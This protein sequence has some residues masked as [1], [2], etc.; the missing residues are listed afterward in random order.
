[1]FK[2]FKERIFILLLMLLN[3]A[4]ANAQV[5]SFDFED[6]S[7]HSSW[8]LNP[9]ANQTLI[10]RAE[11][12]WYIGYSG[13]RSENG[14]Y[15]LFM[16]NDGTHATYSN[17]TG[18]I[19]YA[20]RPISFSA[21]SYVL[22]F[23]WRCNA[24]ASSGEGMYV[25][26]VPVAD[27][28]VKLNSG[29]QVL[30][31]WV[32]NYS[33][34]LT[35]MGG[36]ATWQVFTFD[37]TF[38]ADMLSAF[39]S[40]YYL[41]FIWFQRGSNINTPSSACIDNICIFDEKEKCQPPTKLAYSI[42]PTGLKLSWSGGA[43]HY[44]IKLYD[45]QTNSWEVH[46]GITGKTYT[47][48]NMSEGLNDIYIR[49]RCAEDTL[50]SEYVLFKPFY[51]QRGVRCI[52]YLSL[53]DPTQVTCYLGDFDNQRRNVTRVSMINMLD[54]DWIEY[55][56]NLFALHYMPDEYDPYTNNKLPTKPE[57]AIASI[58]LGRFA[59]TF[60]AC[61][62]YKYKVPDDAKAI[63][64][65]HYAVVLPNPH[66]N[67]PS[68][69]NP[70][71]KM[72]ILANN[73]RLPDSCGI[74][75][76]M[77]ARDVDEKWNLVGEGGNSI[78]WRE[79]DEVA[80]NLR[81]Y[82]GQT[83]TV[84][85]MTTGCSASAHGGYAYFTLDCESGEL[86]GINCGDIPT[87]QFIAPSGFEYEWYLP[88]KPDEILYRGQIYDVNPMDTLTYN[89]D[90]I[91][92]T[93]S[94]C[95]YTLD[96]TAIPRYPVAEYTFEKT[97][98]ICT[99]TYIFHQTCHVK[100]KNQIT[101][102]EWHT[103]LPVETV[104]WDFGDGSE[105]LA[106]TNEYV[107]HTFP[108]DGGDFTVTLSAGI[109]EDLCQV[110]NQQVLKL[111]EAGIRTKV[112]KADICEGKCHMYGGVYYCNTYI[113][114][115][116]YTSVN[117]CDSVIIFNIVSHP[118]NF[119]IKD[120]ICQGTPYDFNGEQ[121]SESGNYTASL[122]SKFNCDSIVHL[123]LYVEP[124]LILSV[125]DT[126]YVC[127]DA[128]I[129]EIPYE[130]VQGNLDSITVFTDSLSQAAGFE[131]EYHFEKDEPI[132]IELPSGVEPSYMFFTLDYATPL[133]Q[134]PSQKVCLEVRYPSSIVKVK[135]G[136]LVVQNEEFSGYK[137]DG[138]QWYR[139]GILL[140][141]ATESF[142]PM[143]SSDEG[144]E[145]TA[146]LTREGK[147]NVPFCPITFKGEATG[148]DDISAGST[149]I[150]PTFAKAGQKI[151]VNQRVSLTIYNA[152]GLEVE[153]LSNITEFSAPQH[154]GVY[155]A[156]VNNGKQVLRFVVH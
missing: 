117:G 17:T 110:H 18:S 93:N 91:S 139:N 62:E 134:V 119:E 16:S 43:T 27:A 60:G 26:L 141:G 69:E 135:D 12:K 82:V 63:L 138:Y 83:V 147:E 145:F 53:D 121:L 35:P 57:G 114:T 84:R 87:T 29:G 31:E 127:A 6:T 105:P 90:V 11:N 120:T 142:L 25:C 71:F 42:S 39:G 75:D 15:G 85:L 44:D 100:Y 89:V 112:I 128:D 151:Y 50:V 56:D 66:E 111:S 5:Y 23:D 51:Y 88:D 146:V 103:D 46:Y 22:S 144:A 70:T 124:T 86:Q 137:F 148:L 74:K 140:E 130:V 30:P 65:V 40:D 116:T 59:P 102:R 9:G 1:M 143:K 34:N 79:W 106:T 132:Q 131:P 149:L 80:V 41:V 154:A 19:M 96:A 55:P 36:K 61:V 32:E 38:D 136:V 123:E 150:S 125:D 92:K 126:T 64:K 109:K 118:R 76:F 129:L 7:D 47:F 94:K 115:L 99:N 67:E 28:S 73:H 2:V 24:S 77:S 72:D 113:D 14:K 52:D 98:D 33:L 81:D 21:G 49:S 13:N 156:T 152:L 48:S 8:Q 95:Y 153:S 155:F 78:Y 101:E 10:N 37:F 4:F 3:I 20:Y 122:T 108:N 97:D 133:C 68:I 45:Y 54:N 104:V 107:V 58:R